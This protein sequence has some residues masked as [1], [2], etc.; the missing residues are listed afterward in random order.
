MGVVRSV[1]V[2]GQRAERLN[3]S[4]GRRLFVE[5]EY[6]DAVS[7]FVA[8]VSPT[9]RRMHGDVA[10][11]V[12]NGCADERRIAGS[13]SP[14]L[15]VETKLV[16]SV[17]AGVWDQRD[18]VCGIENETVGLLCSPDRLK[19]RLTDGT[20]GQ[21]PVNRDFV[22][23]IIRTQQEVAATVRQQVGGIGSALDDADQ[24]EPRGLCVDSK[25][26]QLTTG[27][28]GHKQ[29]P[30]IRRCAQKRRLFR[31][32]RFMSTR[33]SA[34]IGIALKRDDLL[35]FQQRDKQPLT[36]VGL[37]IAAAEDS[38]EE[39]HV[40]ECL[41]AG[42]VFHELVPLCG[43]LIGIGHHNRRDWLRLIRKLDAHFVKHH[44]ACRPAC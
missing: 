26:R 5:G 18:P 6:A 36:G 30:A 8:D 23:Q 19:R 14:G 31:A 3:A 43:V 25:T 22:R 28:K 15:F 12:L 24:L 4:Q 41:N 39:N 29:C 16:D 17:A 1:K 35:F 21:Q 27:A 20:V 38:A 11:M 42:N 10:R 40:Q 34:G 32:I 9:V 2:A 33:E 7:R 37:G 13:Q 44:G